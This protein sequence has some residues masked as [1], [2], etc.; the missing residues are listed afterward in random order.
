MREETTRSSC[1]PD[2][3]SSG[4][5]RSICGIVRGENRGTENETT[6]VRMIWQSRA[7]EGIN[8]AGQEFAVAR[9]GARTESKAN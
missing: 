4:H 3:S 2:L 7:W 5:K 1:W 8:C 6:G 9:F